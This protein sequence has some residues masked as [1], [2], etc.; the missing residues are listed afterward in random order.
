MQ[1]VQDLT[2]PPISSGAA[3]RLHP[4]CHQGRAALVYRRVS[5]IPPHSL[6]IILEYYK[7][8]AKAVVDHILALDKIMNLDLQLVFRATMF[9]TK[10]QWTSYRNLTLN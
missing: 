9:I 3:H 5:A 1:A 8:D 6:P 4:Q 10:A 2:M 7:D